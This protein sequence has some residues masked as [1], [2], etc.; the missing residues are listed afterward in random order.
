MTEYLLISR[1]LTKGVRKWLKEER[2]SDLFPSVI[3][4]LMVMF[5]RTGKNLKELEI[6]GGA[7][8]IEL[9]LIMPVSD[10]LCENN[11]LNL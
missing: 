11:T 10:E 4:S 6:N 8:K 5:L 1:D 3:S 7:S 9:R 2:K